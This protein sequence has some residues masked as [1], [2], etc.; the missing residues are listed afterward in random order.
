MSSSKRRRSFDCR[1]ER[2]GRI[3]PVFAPRFTSVTMPH[4]LFISDLHL[5]PE[6]PAATDA[7]LRFLRGTAPDAD[8]LYVLGDLFEYWIGDEGLAQPF[9]RQFAPA[10]RRL[11]D[12]G[13]PNYF[14]HSHP[15]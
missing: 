3:K 9:V 15:A 4:T 13:L 2:A 7:L 1:H 11:A 8:A 6:T 12:C 14:R 5:S 10:L